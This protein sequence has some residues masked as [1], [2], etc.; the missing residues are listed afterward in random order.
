MHGAILTR[1]DKSTMSLTSG[2]QDP[3]GLSSELLISDCMLFF[4]SLNWDGKAL[5]YSS[6]LNQA[7]LQGRIASLQ[8]IVHIRAISPLSAA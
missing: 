4:T 8:P 1:T 2:Q 5:S 3:M 7:P 6:D